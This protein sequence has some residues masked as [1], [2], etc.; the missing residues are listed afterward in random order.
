MGFVFLEH[1]VVAMFSEVHDQ[2]AIA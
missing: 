2:L 1:G